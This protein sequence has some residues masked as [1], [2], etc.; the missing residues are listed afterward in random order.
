M[1]GKLRHKHPTHAALSVNSFH[2]TECVATRTLDYRVSLFLCLSLSVTVSHR[3]SL[4]SVLCQCCVSVC[5]INWAVHIKMVPWPTPQLILGA[6]HAGTEVAARAA[7]ERAVIGSVSFLCLMCVYRVLMCT[8]V[9]L[10]IQ[11]H[12][13]RVLANGIYGKTIKWYKQL[14]KNTLWHSGHG[15]A[16]LIMVFREW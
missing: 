1:P 13:Q 12:R 8:L 7:S 10:G 14:I 16:I 5:L 4:L 15:V 11:T 3:L 2:S 6:K 9:F